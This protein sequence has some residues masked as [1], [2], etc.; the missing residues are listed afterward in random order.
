MS[1]TYLLVLTDDYLLRLANMLDMT[2]LDLENVWKLVKTTRKSFLSHKFRTKSNGLDCDRA[3][4]YTLLIDYFIKF[5]I[6]S[7][8]EKL[9]LNPTSVPKENVSHKTLQTAGEMFTYLNYCPNKLESII[10][11]ILENGTPKDIILALSIPIKALRKVERK[12][13]TK[14]L[15]KVME[16]LKLETYKNIQM[17]TKG[18]CYTNDTFSRCTSKKSLTNEDIKKLGCFFCNRHKR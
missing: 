17:I 18:I 9:Q 15:S 4:S 1:N 7:L 14:I 12:S 8:A 6:D 10:V 5:N 3:N 16:S 11:Q 2:Q 13:I